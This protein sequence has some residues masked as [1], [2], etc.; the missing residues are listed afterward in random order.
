MHS[1]EQLH[2]VAIYTDV[3]LVAICITGSLTVSSEF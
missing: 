1:V 3:K 2:D